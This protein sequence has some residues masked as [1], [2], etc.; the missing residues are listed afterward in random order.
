MKRAHIR[1]VVKGWLEEAR[2]SDTKGHFEALKKQADKL[3]IE[4]EKLGPSPADAYEV[5][6]EPAPAPAPATPAVNEEH[7]RSTLHCVCVSACACV[8]GCCR[9][10]SVDCS[11]PRFALVAGVDHHGYAAKPA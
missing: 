7:V 2:E 4:L 8:C 9:G 1:K 6:E 3:E 10:C 11:L 5:A